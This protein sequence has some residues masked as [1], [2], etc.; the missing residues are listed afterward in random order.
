MRSRSA[1]EDLL[2]AFAWYHRTIH[3]ASRIILAGSEH[4]CPRYFAMLAMLAGRLGLTDVS[5]E[6]FVSE[7][8]RAACFRV[9]DVFVTTSRH[10]GFCLPLI[11]AMC[12]EVP[13]TARLQGGMP[14]ALEDSGIQRTWRVENF[15]MRHNA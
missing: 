6:G 14:E 3:P 13:V 9:A 7:E 12:R 8:G 5:F 11:E 10:E 4:S 2:L 15:G 1:S